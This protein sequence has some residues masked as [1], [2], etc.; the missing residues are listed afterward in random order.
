MPFNPNPNPMPFNPHPHPTQVAR[1]LVVEPQRRA[2]VQE[3]LSMEAVTV[4]RSLIPQ[5]PP[6]AGEAIVSGPN[7]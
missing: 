1:I 3:I 5:A 7:P 4:N 2:S 6:A